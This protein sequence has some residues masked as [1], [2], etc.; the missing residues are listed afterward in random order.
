MCVGSDMDKYNWTET[1]KKYGKYIGSFYY[2]SQPKK[3]YS[4]L[5][6]LGNNSYAESFSSYDTQ[7][8]AEQAIVDF[9]GNWAWI[10]VDELTKH[11]SYYL[12]KGDTK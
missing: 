2:H 11:T 1:Q 5:L 10:L 9:G 3:R 6:K 8:S 4:L 12:N 7:R